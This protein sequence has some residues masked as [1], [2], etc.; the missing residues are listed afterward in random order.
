MRWLC[1][2]SNDEGICAIIGANVSS[3]RRLYIPSPL[4]YVQPPLDNISST[5]SLAGRYY[6]RLHSHNIASPIN[7]FKLFVL[8]VAWRIPSSLPADSN[9]RTNSPAFMAESTYSLSP[10]NLKTTATYRNH[11]HH[12]GNHRRRW[13][14]PALGMDFSDSWSMCEFLEPGSSDWRE[15]KWWE[16]WCTTHSCCDW[17][18][19]G[20]TMSMNSYSQYYMHPCY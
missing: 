6:D 14:H 13:Y 16:W 3:T 18:V 19:I 1:N 2:T 12:W 8:S 17:L 9:K 15:V 4:V 20:P 7:H 10:E 5:S 11:E